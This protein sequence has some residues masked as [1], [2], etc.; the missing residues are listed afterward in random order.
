MDVVVPAP[1]I[2]LQFLFGPRG[3]TLEIIFEREGD[4]ENVKTGGDS[5]E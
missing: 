5:S 2:L 4:R 1:T 3:G